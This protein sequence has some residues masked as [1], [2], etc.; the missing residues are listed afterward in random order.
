MR[1]RGA[2]AFRLGLGAAVTGCG[3]GLP[4]LHPAR[5]LPL[6]GVRAAGGLTGQVAL[7]GLAAAQRAGSDAIA[8]TSGP[9]PAAD[10][11]YARSALVAAA[12]APGIAPFVSARIGMG[13]SFEGG[14]VYSGRA[15]RA[16]LRRSWDLSPS[17]AFSV[18]LGGSAVLA[19]QSAAHEVQGLD[20]GGLTGWGADVPLLVGYESEAG[21]YMAW[22]GA[23]VGF[24]QVSASGSH[25]GA[26][27][28]ALDA[29]R[30]WGG[31]VVGAAVGFRH[32]HFAAEVD[33]SYASVRGEYAGVHGA[34]A[35]MTLAPSTAVWWTF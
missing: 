26:P 12:V 13:D 14:V 9:N 15:L 22:V 23:R 7:G 8:A 19:G 17:M 32:V 34:V 21:L 30:F 35:G 6:G 5:T 16:D 28:A 10:S 1:R 33:A 4:L 2:L 25:A 3:G 29:T 11:T 20:L 24:E 27:T 18:G 31:G